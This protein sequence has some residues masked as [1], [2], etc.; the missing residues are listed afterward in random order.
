M[1]GAWC[2]A[3]G[4][5]VDS[6]RWPANHLLSCVRGCWP[7]QAAEC[8]QWLTRRQLIRD[9]G[10]RRYVTQPEVQQALDVGMALLEGLG[11][12]RSTGEAV[13]LL[14]LGRL[15]AVGPERI[16]PPVDSFQAPSHAQIPRS[17]DSEE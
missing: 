13:D 12:P 16:Q 6:L 1:E 11:D 4:P 15:R 10:A 2:K 8:G 17:G 9:G 5:R 3:P 7:A 14:E